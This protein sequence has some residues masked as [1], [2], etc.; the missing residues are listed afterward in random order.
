[1]DLGHDFK[2]NNNNINNNYNW[3]LCESVYFM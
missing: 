1:M 2:R 3:I